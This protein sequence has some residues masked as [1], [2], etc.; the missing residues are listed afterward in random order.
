MRGVQG[1]EVIEKSDA[2]C[3]FETHDIKDSWHHAG[4]GQDFGHYPWRK[5][6]MTNWLLWLDPLI[7]D[8]IQKVGMSLGSSVET[9][10]LLCNVLHCLTGRSKIF[11]P[12]F[13]ILSQLLINQKTCLYFLDEMS[14]TAAQLVHLSRLKIKTHIFVDQQLAL[15]HELFN[16]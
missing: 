6:K 15:Y 8:R 14:L 4:W 16:I 7:R 2:K 3:D 1:S 5:P 13:C 11:I 9:Y 12:T 10:F